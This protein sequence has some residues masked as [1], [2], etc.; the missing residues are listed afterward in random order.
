M[1][2]A[3]TRRFCLIFLLSLVFIAGGFVLD[4]IISSLW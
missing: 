3:G 4:M 2:Q 1:T